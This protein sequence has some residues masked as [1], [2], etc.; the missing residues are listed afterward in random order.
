[1]VVASIDWTHYA[2]FDL[3]KRDNNLNSGTDNTKMTAKGV[4]ICRD[5][6][7]S[8]QNRTLNLDQPVKIGRSVARTRAAPNNAIFDC[9]VLSRNHALLWYNAGKFYLQDT[10][11]SNGTFVNNQRLSAIGSESAAKEVCSGDIVQ[12]GV[13]VVESMKKITH[14]CIIATLKLY[15]PDGKEAKASKS[16][17]VPNPVG[18]VTV[19]DLYKLNQ[20]LQEATRREKLLN[21]KLAC[22][23]KLVENTKKAANQSWKALIDEDRLLSHIK[24]AERQL[25]VYS[26]NFNEDRIRKELIKREEEKSQY[27]IAAKE[28]LEKVHQEKLQITEKLI[29]LESRLNETEEECQSLHEISK[30]SQSELQDLTIKYMT[31]QHSLA[32]LEAKLVDKE[33][34][35]AEIVKWSTQEREDL[36]KKIHHHA[37]VGQLLRRRISENRLDSVKIHKQITGLK[38][39][40]QTLQDIN[41]KLLSEDSK[42]GINPIEI[43]NAIL[44]TLNEMIAETEK[45]EE[46]LG[47]TED[48]NC[49]S[50]VDS[51]QQI[52]INNSQENHYKNEYENYTGSN[53]NEMFSEYILPPQ[54]ARR[55]LVNGK[56]SSDLNSEAS[57]NNL[58]TTDNTCNSINDDL[59]STTTIEDVTEKSVIETKPV[60]DYSLT[61]SDQEPDKFRVKFVHYEA[62][63][64]F[65]EKGDED[66]ADSSNHSASFAS[67]VNE[68]SLES[69]EENSFEINEKTDTEDEH[70]EEDKE[71]KNS[72]FI[73]TLKPVGKNTCDCSLQHSYNKEYILQL[74]MASLE[75]LDNDDDIEVQQLVKQ[76]LNDLRNWLVQ[77]TSDTILDKLKE[78]YYRTKNE[79]SRMQEVNEELVLVKEQYNSC[80]EDKLEISRKFET[81]K[82]QCGDILDTSYSVPIQY[83]VPVFVAFLCLMLDKIF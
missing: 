18:D 15:L 6:S 29:S 63:D 7:H 74:L 22:L 81:L 9:K 48:N 10:R 53:D 31:A 40:I 57:N 56:S 19:E 28:A 4:L 55:T 82:S 42:D 3:S 27:Q 39:Y 1:M 20:Y 71:K 78:I 32:Q 14:G 68:N 11:S 67:S 72:E 2:D 33:E 76:E 80:S 24:L 50:D 58:E 52:F 65:S 21:S 23:E 64:G 16:T 38:N 83:F 69:H 46:N 12:F 61:N 73:K 49:K 8:F 37:K 77:E 35:S 45:L 13:D 26:K 51:N 62:S 60:E 5:N 54:N 44:D 59:Y 25:M 36:I 30:H 70:V 17:F 43:I 79:K 66:I 34:S 75:S 47:D 41:S